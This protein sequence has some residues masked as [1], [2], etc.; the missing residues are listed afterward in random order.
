MNTWE[1]SYSLLFCSVSVLSSQRCSS[2]SKVVTLP[3][4]GLDT[5]REEHLRG[6]LSPRD[7]LV[8]IHSHRDK[9][10]DTHSPRDKVADIHSPRDKV[11]DIHSPRDKVVD[12]HSPRDKVVEL[13]LHQLRYF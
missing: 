6:I 8:D 5:S 9:V 13:V 10:V 11:V 2:H 12:I 4:Q 1:E 7:K 3:N